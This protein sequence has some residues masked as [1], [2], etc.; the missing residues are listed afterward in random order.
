M[1]LVKA[2]GRQA[3]TIGLPRAGDNGSTNP[4]PEENDP[5][6]TTV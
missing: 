5:G 6:D 4:R 1:C 3:E 2:L